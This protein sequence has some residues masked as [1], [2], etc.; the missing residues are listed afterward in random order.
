MKIEEIFSALVDFLREHY[1]DQDDDTK[2][3]GTP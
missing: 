3:E 2:A 1:E